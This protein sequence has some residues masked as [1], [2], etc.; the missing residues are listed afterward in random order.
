MRKYILS[1]F[2]SV[3]G[4]LA[5]GQKIEKNKE[6]VTLSNEHQTLSFNLNNGLFYILNAEREKVIDYA[7]FQAGGLQSKEKEAQRS[8]TQSIIQ[9]ELGEGTCLTIRVSF[10]NYSDILWQ[11]ILYKGKNYI[12]FR[13]GIENDFDQEYRLTTFWPLISH[14]V[15]EGL[16]NKEGYRILDGTGGGGKTLVRTQNNLTSFNNLMFRFGQPESL[17]ILVAGGLTYH[18]FEKFVTVK[19]QDKKF[20]LLLFSEDPVGKLIPSGQT[21]LPD[22]KFYLCIN[23]HN[24][25]EALEQYGKTLQRAQNIKLNQYDFPTE[26]LWYASFYNNEKGRRKFNDSKGAC[27]EMDNAIKSG[28]TQYT[29]VAIRLVPDTYTPNNQQGW[30]DD[31]HW[32]MYGEP[33]STD[34]PHYVAPYLTTQSWAQEIKKKEGL[35]ITYFQ[36]AHRSEDFAKTHPEYM[37]FNDKYRVINQPERFLQ[38]VEHS[39]EYGD[40]GGYYNHWW[41]DKMLWSYDFTDTGFIQ[42]MKNVYQ[43]L[44]EAGIKGIMY[45]YPEITAWA[46]EGGFEDKHA[47]TAW[48]YRNMYQLAYDGL[49]EDCYLDERCLLRG[50]DIT[51]GLVSSQ[52]VW[53]DTDGITPEMVARC[54]LRWYKNR[55]VVNYD[56]DAKDP[57]D[58]LPI[59]H[60]DGNRSM[61]TMC[62]VTSGRFLLG[63][64]FKQLSHEQLH[65]LS[66]TFPYH[67]NPQSAR[68]LDAFNEG[69]TF[70]RIYDFKINPAWHQLTLYNYIDTNRTDF[71]H[72]EIALNAL[73][74]AGGLALNPNKEYYL[75]DFWN[76]QYVGKLQ[77]NETLQQTLR[78]G[79][80]RML[81]IH[82]KQNIPQFISTD[83]HLMQGFLD[84]KNCRWNDNS[85]TLTGESDIVAEEPY[86]I[87]I[88]TNGKK[89][90]KCQIKG[91][92]AS[93]K[94]VK[95]GIIKLSLQCKHSGLYPWSI[96]FQ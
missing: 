38:H 32:G 89:A 42:H 62:Y 33:M 73:E 68:P 77:G 31:K 82:E 5:I 45:D 90:I 53:A 58:A 30:W 35:P 40:G 9:D 17:N 39:A 29:R 44:K 48:A 96:K 83:R 51:L 56:M 60:A 15:F 12:V 7:Y 50:S 41:T 13:M 19:R 25:F 54:G 3:I 64:S 65:D 66:R 70:P 75:Y 34:G 88:A 55:L 79:E 76:D 16:S 20:S 8:Y 84:L 85:N 1:I 86:T 26:C 6:W 2:F 78:P 72:F 47:T 59:E 67:T 92:K 14:R 63:R 43:N 61:L 22:E 18:E 4:I 94:T 46:F 80:A 49:G 74:N 24:Q 57:S 28:I 10:E 95:D 69:V 81:S 11:A 52:R 37:L 23:D 21:Y 71:N 93:I 36:S 91:G 27:E 87:V